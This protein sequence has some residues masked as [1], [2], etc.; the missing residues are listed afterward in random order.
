MEINRQKKF[1]VRR[2]GH[3]NSQNIDDQ[4][5]LLEDVIALYCGHPR[6]ITQLSPEGEVNSGG[7]IPRRFTSRYVFSAVHRPR[8]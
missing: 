6:D 2:N 5:F 3:K 4:V 7:Y 1:L 8:C